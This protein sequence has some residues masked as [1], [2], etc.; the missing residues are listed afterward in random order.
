M[1]ILTWLRL[2]EG[3]VIVA[4]V[5]DDHI[6]LLLRLR[7]M[8]TLNSELIPRTYHITLKCKV[9]KAPML[10]ISCEGASAA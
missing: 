1:A 3:R 8:N 2:V 5:P 4:A 7:A 6:R 9:R 10:H